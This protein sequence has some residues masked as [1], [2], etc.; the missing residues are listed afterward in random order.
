MNEDV[1]KGEWETVTGSH[2]W[3]K[4]VDGRDS[5]GGTEWGKVCPKPF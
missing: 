3:R 5:A 1:E 2:V 4:V